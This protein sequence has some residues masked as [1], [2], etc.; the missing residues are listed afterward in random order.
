M[1]KFY[2][3]YTAIMVV[4]ITWLSIMFVRDYREAAEK[5]EKAKKEGDNI[6]CGDSAT[7]QDNS[8]PE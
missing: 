1:L 5:A 4:G 6:E 2:L 3:T 8:R 7:E